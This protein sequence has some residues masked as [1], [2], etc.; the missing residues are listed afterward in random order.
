M[1]LL[2]PEAH[3]WNH[4]ALSDPEP[5][6]VAHVRCIIVLVNHA[7]AFVG[8][9]QIYWRGRALQTFK[10]FLLGLT[11]VPVDKD[12]RSCKYGAL[13]SKANVQLIDAESRQHAKDEGAYVIQSRVIEGVIMLAT[14]TNDNAVDGLEISHEV[15]CALGRFLGPIDEM[16]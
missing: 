2:Y 6:L 13:V 5:P 16:A 1:R 15:S 9:S 10:E 7:N 4:R 11:A 8:E 14:E 3:L 12:R